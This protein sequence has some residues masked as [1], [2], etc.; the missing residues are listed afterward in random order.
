LDAGAP[1]ATVEE[2]KVSED[3]A[4]ALRAGPHPAGT[5]PAHSTT[6]ALDD[7]AAEQRPPKPRPRQRRLELAVLRRWSQAGLCPRAE[8]ATEAQRT[9][10]RHFRA[11][12][13]GVGARVFLDPRLPA[14]AEQPALE[15]LEEAQRILRSELQLSPGVPD[16]FLYQDVHLLLASA[17]TNADVVAYYDG[18]LHVVVTRDDVRESVLHEFTHHALMAAG[19]LGPAWIQEGMAMHIAR[20]TWWRRSDLLQSLIDRPFALNTM[21]T[22]VPYTLESEQAVLFYAQ[23]AAMVECS[24]REPESTLSGLLSELNVQQTGEALEYGLPALAEITALR[25]CLRELQQEPPKQ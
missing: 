10:M 1:L 11:S 18:S 6:A 8:Q 20:E 2:R 15:Y 4:G 12:E 17:C 24:L 7:V 22:I 16:M 19:V 9:L 23:S 13:L 5:L 21:E 14:G 3:T 25:E